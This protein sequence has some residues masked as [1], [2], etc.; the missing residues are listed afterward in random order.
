MI[1]LG[2]QLRWQTECAVDD[3]QKRSFLAQD[4]LL[5]LRHDEILSRL[6]IALQ[7]LP[8][9]LIGCK[10]VKGNQAPRDI[11]GAFVG[12][13]IANK[14]AAAARDDA[15]PVL[16]ILLEAIAL[17]RVNLISDKAGNRHGCA[18]HVSSI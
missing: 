9:G 15:P 2:R 14:M 16:G 10:A 18:P 11:V 8:I 5:G 7:A 1:T 6:W 17:K 3:F 4:K 13:K 12:K